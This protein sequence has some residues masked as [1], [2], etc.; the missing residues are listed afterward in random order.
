MLENDDAAQRVPV[1]KRS[2]FH[3]RSYALS[4]LFKRR[5]WCSHADD[6]SHQV[7]E[8]DTPRRHNAFSCVPQTL[9]LLDSTWAACC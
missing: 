6:V 3:T 8:G 7:D 5:L 2:R 9:I 1:L 4:R